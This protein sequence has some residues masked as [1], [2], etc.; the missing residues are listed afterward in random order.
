[1]IPYILNYTIEET[2]NT[3]PTNEQIVLKDLTGLKFKKNEAAY[4]YK[5]LLE[6][7]WHLSEKLKRDVGMRVAAIDFVENFYQSN[8]SKSNQINS[9]ANQVKRLVQPI[10]TTAH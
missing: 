4:L 8:A 1:M 9:F 7:K 2:L 5:R 3:L 10:F 6:H